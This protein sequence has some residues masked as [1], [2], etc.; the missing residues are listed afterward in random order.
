MQPITK[1]SLL[2]LINAEIKK[3]PDHD[4]EIF[5]S[6]VKQEGHVFVFY[7]DNMLNNPSK[8]ILANEL[9]AAIDPV[10]NGKFLLID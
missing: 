6:D 7:A 10:F 9:I 2:D 1:K 5:I 4:G 3:H 8:M